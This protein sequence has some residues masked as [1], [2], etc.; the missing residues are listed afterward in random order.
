MAKDLRAQKNLETIN[1][2][3]KVLEHLFNLKDMRV[4]P[5]GLRPFISTRAYLDMM[6]SDV[7]IVSRLDKTRRKNAIL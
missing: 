6:P 1:K 5:R 4:R 3:P 7:P 2:T